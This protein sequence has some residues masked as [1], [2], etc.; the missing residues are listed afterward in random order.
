MKVYKRRKFEVEGC[1]VYRC[2]EEWAA[3][4]R[5]PPYIIE[6]V[7]LNNLHSTLGCAYKPFL[8]LACLG[9]G[10]KYPFTS[11]F[12]L[13]CKYQNQERLPTYALPPV[14]FH[15][16]RRFILNNMQNSY[17]KKLISVAY[18]EKILLKIPLLFT[19]KQMW[20]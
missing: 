15:M 17:I 10:V 16:T 6:R 8:C 19:I 5:A 18:K 2:K 4:V 13:Q 3:A 11:F 12:K 14:L 9:L 20:F 1:G 7:A